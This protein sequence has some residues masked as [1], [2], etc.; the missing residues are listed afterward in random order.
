ML[1]FIAQTF[2]HRSRAV[3]DVGKASSGLLCPLLVTLYRKDIIKLE[4]VWKRFTR[5]LLGIKGLSYNDRLDSLELFLL[6]HRRL[7]GDLIEVYKIM[8]DVDKEYKIDIADCLLSDF[9][10]FVSF[11]LKHGILLLYSL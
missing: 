7:K 8:R 10:T 1:D 5:M 11:I 4:R 6:D 3:Q 2:E 9:V